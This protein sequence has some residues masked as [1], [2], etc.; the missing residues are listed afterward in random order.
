MCNIFCLRQV[1]S[2]SL[3]AVLALRRTQL[4]SARRVRTLCSFYI[5]G[6][7]TVSLATDFMSVL[8]L[9]ELLQTI[10]LLKDN[11]VPGTSTF[12]L[13]CLTGSTQTNTSDF[14]STSGLGLVV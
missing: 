14:N 9:Q 1:T 2:A 5:L 6:M 3:M 10:R 12:P 11:V 4:A 13:Y 7:M 8:Q